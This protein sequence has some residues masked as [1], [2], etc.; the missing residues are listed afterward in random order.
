MFTITK[1]N[2]NV[3]ADFT[4]IYK[5]EQDTVEHAISSYSFLVPNNCTINGDTFANLITDY[6]SDIRCKLI[7]NTIKRISKL[8]VIQ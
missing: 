1:E 3:S 8:G 2:F 4:V 5:T 6:S 7:A